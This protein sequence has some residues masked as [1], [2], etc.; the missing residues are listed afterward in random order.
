M[1]KRCFSREAFLLLAQT[2]NDI[3]PF[4]EPQKPTD[5]G[6]TKPCPSGK[7]RDSKTGKCV[8]AKKKQKKKK[9]TTPY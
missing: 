9:I 7:K 6:K 2:T 4:K 8:E 3:N 1:T 5:G